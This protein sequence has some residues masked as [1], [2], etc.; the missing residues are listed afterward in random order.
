M[1]NPAVSVPDQGAMHGPN[2]RQ[3]LTDSLVP[4]LEGADLGSLEATSE[5]LRECAAMS[6]HLSQT[7]H[8]NFAK[9]AEAL[10]VLAESSDGSVL[11]LTSERVVFL[12]YPATVRHVINN[13]I[14]VD[15][16]LGD[17][18]ILERVE[19]PKAACCPE[20]M[21]KNE[22]LR[23]IAG[24]KGEGPWVVAIGRTTEQ[25]EKDRAAWKT[26]L[27]GLEMLAG[28]EEKPPDK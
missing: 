24:K 10:G 14:I 12:V 8:P 28:G 1:T 2:L 9:L 22:P 3:L 26:L 13:S 27:D 20:P 19:V 7:Q 21:Q 5:R 18:W 11:D 6:R 17:N 23:L 25:Q 15:A 4:L 16:D